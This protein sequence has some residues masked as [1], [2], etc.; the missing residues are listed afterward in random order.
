MKFMIS[1]ENKNKYK[2]IIMWFAAIV[3]FSFLHVFMNMKIEDDNTFQNALHDGGI[4][5]FV[6]DEYFTWSSRILINMVDEIF[7]ALPMWVWQI[8]DVII[9]L[10]LFYELQQICY[11]KFNNPTTFV[12]LGLLCSFRFT[13]MASAGWI[14]TT[15]NYLW[16][17]AIGLHCINALFGINSGKK[18]KW[19]QYV[20]IIAAFLFGCSS[21]LITVIIF[22]SFIVAHLV[23]LFK[24]IEF[25][26]WY[27]IGGEVVG[28]ISLIIHM[29]CPGSKARTIREI[30]RFMPEFD[31]LSV[32][33]KLKLNYI[34]T[35]THFI[36]KP[37]VLFFLVCFLIMIGIFVKYNSV[38]KRLISCIPLVICIMGTI[39]YF[40]MQQKGIKEKG[41][42]DPILHC[43]SRYE[44]I[45]QM[46]MLI[47]FTILILSIVT[48]LYWI[49]MDRFLYMELLFVL[50]LGFAT[51]MA[52]SFSPTMFASSTRIY[53]YLYFSLIF[54]SAVL[55]ELLKEYFGH[56]IWGMLILTLMAG[57]GVNLITLIHISQAI[58]RLH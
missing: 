21:E 50:A 9:I 39:Y 23:Y 41:Y 22:S 14:A 32:L 49:V 36:S 13:H 33:D 2:V 4:I 55:V 45:E 30:E 43:T 3:F 40:L 47:V 56:K 10:L 18:Y 37:N 34:A 51:R 15:I 48:N 35:F 7:M 52:L 28:L 38:M 8:A 46:I 26:K 44:N 11:D 29:T 25:P 31:S 24:K 1:Q 53:T 16:P 5:K 20:V 19:Y 27:I 12:L 6:I 54:I 57:A 17:L 42:D 58:E